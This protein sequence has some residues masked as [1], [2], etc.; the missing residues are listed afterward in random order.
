[1]RSFKFFAIFLSFF[2]VQ[3][4]LAD[5]STMTNGTMDSST[6]PAAAAT[7]TSD[8]SPM[9]G[10]CAS[11]AAACKT[12]GFQRDSSMSGKQF[13][14]DCMKP[15]ILGKVV[16]GVTVDSATI[17]ACKVTKIEQLKNELKELQD[18]MATSPTTSS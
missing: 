3:A 4:V 11:V 9:N 14:Q 18:S 17:Q 12:A 7:S 16:P 15:L 10:P 8:M 5:D 2:M 6:M 1:M 13:W